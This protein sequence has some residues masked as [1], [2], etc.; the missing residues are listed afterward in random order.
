VPNANNPGYH[1]SVIGSVWKY[2]SSTNPQ[3]EEL[4]CALDNESPFKGLVV[5]KKM[6]EF[7]GNGGGKHKRAIQPSA[8][9]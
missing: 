8:E 7:I 1:K 9:G 3:Q 5:D 2:K 4:Y 6:L